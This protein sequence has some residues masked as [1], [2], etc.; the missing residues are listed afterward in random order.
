MEK[1]FVI[2]IDSSTTSCKAIAWDQQG[3]AIAEG[4][5]HC[6]VLRPYPAWSEQDAREWWHAA[7]SALKELSGFVDLKQAGALC[8]TAQRESFVLLDRQGTPVRPA[9]LW[10]DERGRRQVASLEKTYGADHF[11]RLTGKH[12]SLS[13]ALPKLLWLMEHEP[14]AFQYTAKILDTH[15]YLIYRFSGDFSTSL[16]CAD[17]LGLV[18]MPSQTWSEEILHASGLRLDQLP[19]LVPP[20]A[21]IAHVS[22][23]GAADSGLAV[24]LPIAAGAGDG[25]CAGLGANAIGSERVYLNLGT[26]VV[27]GAFSAGY[28]VDTAFRTHYAPMPGSFFLETVIRGGGSTV[29]WFVNQFGGDL[30][31][32]PTRTPEEALEA[33]AREVPPGSHGLVVLPYWNSVMNPYWDPAATGV[34]LGWTAAHG[35]AHFYRAILE[36]IAFEQKLASDGMMAALGQR[37]TEYVTVGGGSRSGLWCQIISDVTGIPVRRARTVEASCLGAGILAAV[38]AGWYP[39]VTSAASAMTAVAEDFTPDLEINALYEKLYREVYLPFF[40]AIQPLVD[41]LT[42]LSHPDSQD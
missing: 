17:P 33:L 22:P 6:A 7:C 12:P 39:D 32:N 3:R 16:A 36:G 18:D 37:F 38:A 11:H 23:A 25:Q 21:I 34:T 30:R 20:G 10:L 27:S 26:A 2:G 15:A 40:P 31:A 1:P 24:G 5:A 35:R 28:L 14:D 29:S 8:V 42:A 9:V 19:A 4:R 41:R 13:L